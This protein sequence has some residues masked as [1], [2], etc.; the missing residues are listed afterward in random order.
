MALASFAVIVHYR[1]GVTSL[2]R[3]HEVSLRVWRSRQTRRVQVPVEAT[4]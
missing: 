1:A 4:P 2:A 3:L